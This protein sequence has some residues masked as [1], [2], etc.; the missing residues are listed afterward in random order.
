MDYV[1]DVIRAEQLIWSLWR[2][3][4]W[5]AG[6]FFAQTQNFMGSQKFQ[7]ENV[8]QTIVSNFEPKCIAG[9]CYFICDHLQTSKISSDFKIS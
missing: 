8:F 9:D 2:V 7:N 3:Y 4:A 1:Y 5:L 6:W